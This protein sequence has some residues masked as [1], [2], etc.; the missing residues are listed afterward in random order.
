MVYPVIDV[1]FDLP[2]TTHTDKTMTIAKSAELG[3]L[4]I[5]WSVTKDGAA[6]ELD[7]VMSG[8]LGQRRRYHPVCG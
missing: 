3:N 5:A 8:S 6:A 2:E 7:S 1:S 4:S